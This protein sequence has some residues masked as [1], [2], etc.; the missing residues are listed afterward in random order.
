M[1]GAAGKRYDR[2]FHSK[3]YERDARHEYSNDEGSI[4]M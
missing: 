2:M 4:Y 1:D 3:G